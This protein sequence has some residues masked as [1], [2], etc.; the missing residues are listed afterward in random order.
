MYGRFGGAL[1]SLG[2]VGRFIRKVGVPFVYFGF[3]RRG[4]D[5]G[6]GIAPHSGA[7]GELGVIEIRGGNPMVVTEITLFLGGFGGTF[8]SSRAVG[9]SIGEV[10]V[11]FGGVL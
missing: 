6:G 4:S 3:C 7:A 2:A 11:P 8:W 9:R 1:R 5:C 10:G